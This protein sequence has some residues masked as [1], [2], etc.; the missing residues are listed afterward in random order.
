M[1]TSLLLQRVVLFVSFPFLFCFMP[2]V[3]DAQAVTQTAPPTHCSCFSLAN[4]AAL[5]A[6]RV[7]TGGDVRTSSPWTGSDMCTWL[8]VGC[9]GADVMSIVAAGRGLRG[10]LPGVALAQLAAMRLFDVSNNTLSG[11]LPPELSAWTNVSTFFVVSNNALTGSLPEA[12]GLS[13][14]SIRAFPAVR[15]SISGELPA[16]YST[17]G[18][19][20]TL[21]D[22]GGATA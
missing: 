8:G 19:T 20:L 10:S 7:A 14:A 3:A 22:V 6:F 12:Y 21:F 2:H 9:D 17:W 11:R 5:E 4:Q 15:N 18:S 1:Q 13:W 16:A